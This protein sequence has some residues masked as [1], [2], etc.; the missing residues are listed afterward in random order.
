MPIHSDDEVS[1]DDDH[2][3]QRRRMLLH[4]NGFPISGPPPVGQQVPVAVTIQCPDPLVDAKPAMTLGGSSIT[5]N[6]AAISRAAMEKDAMDVMK[7]RR[8]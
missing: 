1:L 8:P 5:D 6:A 7:Q 2:P 4:S 3:L